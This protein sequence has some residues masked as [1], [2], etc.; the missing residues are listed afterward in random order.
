MRSPPR[1][2]SVIIF[3][4]VINKCCS[5]ATIYSPLY[6]VEKC[7]IWRQSRRTSLVAA[8]LRSGP[9]RLLE[10]LIPRWVIRLHARTLTSPWTSIF[11]RTEQ[12]KE[13]DIPAPE[14]S[15]GDYIE[16]Y[17]PLLE[18]KKHDMAFSYSPG[19]PDNPI[20]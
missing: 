2:V 6:R 12:S 14:M 15:K 20:T 11:A 18:R 9:D 10:T 3:K 7:I 1:S 4:L 19:V 13:R 5:L 16:F 8:E 17:R